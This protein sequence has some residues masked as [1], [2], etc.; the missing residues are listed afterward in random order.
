MNNLVEYP[1]GYSF[2]TIASGPLDEIL[3]KGGVGRTYGIETY[4]E[5]QWRQFSSWLS[6]TY[7]VNTRQFEGIN[8]GEAY[9]SNFD[10]RHDLS[11]SL[12]YQASKKWNFN[13]V[14]NLQS[15][16]PFTAPRA[17]IRNPGGLEQVVYGSRNN[18][19][20]PVYHRLDLG[21]EYSFTKKGRDRKWS[22]GII[23][24]YNRVNP[25]YYRL[26]P[27]M[28]GSNTSGTVDFFEN[29]YSG[30]G[31]LPFLPYVSYQ[32]NLFKNRK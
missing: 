25:F 17:I 5:M 10:R 14:W 2:Y 26:F 32:I 15:G 6:Y 3:E 31:F 11:L 4:Y 23:N 13:A 1:Y 30:Q 9:F 28:T 24:A 8:Q 12:N 19:R 16:R 21:A 27:K 22:F 29:Q 18:S 7:S 20:L